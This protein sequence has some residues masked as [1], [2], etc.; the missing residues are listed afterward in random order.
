M[1]P[2][3]GLSSSGIGVSFNILAC[4]MKSANGEKPAKFLL[5]LTE[6]QEEHTCVQIVSSE[7]KGVGS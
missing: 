2:S 3:W 4:L 5:A 1:K 7:Q 6:F